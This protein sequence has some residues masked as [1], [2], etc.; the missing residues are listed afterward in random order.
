M[1]AF[2]GLANAA[3]G[4]MQGLMQGEEIAR[5][6]D[7]EDADREFERKQRD[8][9]EKEWNRQDST[10]QLMGIEDEA[11]RV[12]SLR[13]SGL[14]SE[15]L[16]EEARQKEVGQRQKAFDLQMNLGNIQLQDAQR[17]QIHKAMAD[18]FSEMSAAYGSGDPNAVARASAIHGPAFEKLMPNIASMEITGQWDQRNGT[19]IIKYTTKDDPKKIK[20]TSFDEM[21]QR[22]QNP[23]FMHEVQ[24]QRQYHKDKAMIG[25]E[26][27]KLGLMARTSQQQAPKTAED[28]WKEAQGTGQWTDPSAYNFAKASFAVGAS[29]KF[30]KLAQSSG[31][32]EIMAGWK[33]DKATPYAKLRDMYVASELNQRGMLDDKDLESRGITKEEFERTT[34]TKWKAPTPLFHPELFK[35]LGMTGRD[36]APWEPGY[37][38]KSK[39]VTTGG[40]GGM[41]GRT[42]VIPQRPGGID[43][44]NYVP[45]PS[46]GTE[47]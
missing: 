47:Y 18:A 9:L 11:E 36:L 34:G 29:D 21:A 30:D 25:L 6:R 41:G 14:G 8:R 45:T 31:G 7:K 44:S 13:A 43:P 22:T 16:A 24:S 20:Y 23:Y 33:T 15:A 12:K 17:D 32:A 1:R 39:T 26:Q 27:Q 42:A 37:K 35:K 3:S 10:R 19:K 5:R 4:A 38:V 46:D 40:G 2:V 28:Y